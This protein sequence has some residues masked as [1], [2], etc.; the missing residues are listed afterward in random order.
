M[1]ENEAFQV[2]CHSR[3][4]CGTEVTNEPQQALND[5]DWRLIREALADSV[6]TRRALGQENTPYAARIT[7]LLDKMDGGK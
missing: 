5:S 4:W 7:G 2:W 1:T 6:M 3:D